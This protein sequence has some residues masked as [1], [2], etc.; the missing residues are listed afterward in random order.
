MKHVREHK[1]RVSAWGDCPGK[2]TVAG[3]AHPSFSFYH[4]VYPVDEV[5][6]DRL[7][8]LWTLRL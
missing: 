4:V 5:L 7:Y 1:S 2:L 8:R 3:D 6:S